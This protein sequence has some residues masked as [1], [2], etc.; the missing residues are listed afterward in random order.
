MTIVVVIT[1]PCDG[2]KPVLCGTAGCGSAACAG[3][4]CGSALCGAGFEHAAVIAS[5]T[6]N[7]AMAR[8][9][10]ASLLSESSSIHATRFAGPIRFAQLAT[11]DLAGRIARQA[12]REV[13]RLGH[14]VVGDARPGEGDDVLRGRVCFRFQHDDRLDGFAPFVV[15]HAD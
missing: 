1:M 3:S 15:G 6:A 4:A 14:L 2:G 12:L 9:L 13:D 11:Q 8:Y 5:A 7:D 10:M